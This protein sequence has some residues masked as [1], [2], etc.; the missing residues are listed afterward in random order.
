MTSLL[1]LL[2]WAELGRG[3]VIRVG[4]SY[5]YDVTNMLAGRR[6]QVTPF[7]SILST[8]RHFTL[9][10]GDGC[11]VPPSVG[12]PRAWPGHDPGLVAGGA[13]L[14][15]ALARRRGAA[16]RPGRGEAGHQLC[17]V[18]SA[19]RR[20]WP[21]CAAGTSSCASSP[22]WRQPTPSTTSWPGRPVADV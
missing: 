10:D 9:Y 1:L 19:V 22:P 21:G 13:Q 15:P 12:V 2:C 18:T 6:F 4:D 20:W 14:G 17:P 8:S 7:T 11:V 3:S 16:G 5:Y